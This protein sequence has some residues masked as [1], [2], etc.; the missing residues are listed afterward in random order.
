MEKIYLG[1]GAYAAFDGN[2][3]IVTAEDGIRATDTV[4]LDTEALLAL[5]AFAKHVRVIG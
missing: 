3:I 1:D 2:S 5:I 4:I